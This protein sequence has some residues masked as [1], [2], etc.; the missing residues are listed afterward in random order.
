[1]KRGLCLYVITFLLLTAAAWCYGL[2]KRQVYHEG[3]HTTLLCCA[4]YQYSDYKELVARVDHFGQP[5]MLSRMDIVVDYPNP[6]PIPYPYPVPTIYP[7]L[8]FERVFPH[9]LSAFLTFIVLTFFVAA[10]ALSWRVRRTTS[11]WLPQIAIWSTFVFGFPLFFLIDRANIEAVLW[12]L[13]VLGLVAFARNRMVIAA[14]LW[15]CAASMKIYP[16]LFFVLFIAKRKYRIFCLAVAATAI[17]SICALAGVGPTIRQ[18]AQESSATTTPFVQDNYILSRANLGF[19]HSVF[20]GAKQGVYLFIIR[21]WQT[22]VPPS[23]QKEWE[24]H[25]YRIAE[26]IY[27]IIVI[28]G[29]GLLYWFRLRHLPLLNQFMAYVL[30]C[31]TLPYLSA[32]YTLVHVYTAWSAFLLFLVTDVATGRVKLPTRAINLI[33]VSSALCFVSLPYFQWKSIM[34][35]T[36]VKTIFL[37]LILWVVARVPM[38]SSLFGDLRPES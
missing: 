36:H 19:D 14:I 13:V 33:L 17:F 26:H 37:L 27:T 5:H 3:L 21:P 20:A 4:Y 2:I 35:G 6:V 31:V 23:S 25:I 22:R 7:F 24:T 1:V 10:A 18:A 30:L 16:G 34:L 9:P 29:V 28:L 38:P 8:F 32:D 15:S 12:L 11:G